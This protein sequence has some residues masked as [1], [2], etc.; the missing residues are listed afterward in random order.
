[1]GDPFVSATHRA[2]DLASG[3]VSDL[4]KAYQE[5]VERWFLEPAMHLAHRQEPH[6]GLAILAILFA[7]YETHG[8]MLTGKR[9]TN[10][11]DF[12]KGIKAVFKNAPGN[13]P[14]WADFYSKVRCGLVHE[15]IPG[16]FY[17][18]PEPK[19]PGV[20]FKQVDG[21]WEVNPWGLLQWTEE[22]FEA[23]FRGLE[24]DPN[25]Q[26]KFKKAFRDTYGATISQASRKAGETRTARTGSI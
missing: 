13:N 24:H 5:Q 11:A 9:T 20:C 15:G 26:D 23:Y 14:A 7:L 25:V 18:V 22:Y 21:A 3:S 2:S 17:V 10:E 4:A 12:T 6:D 1:M 16:G 8:R 19:S